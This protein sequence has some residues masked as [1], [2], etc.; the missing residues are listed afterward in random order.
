MQRVLG[1]VVAALVLAGCSSPS[2]GADSGPAEDPQANVTAPGAADIDLPEFFDC[3]RRND[4]VIIAA[5]R[6]G[7]LPGYPENAIETM[8]HN[9]D[10]GIRLFEIDVAETRD[11]VLML[12]HDDRVNRTTNGSGYVS[13]TSWEDMSGLRLVDND[14]AMTD[15]HPPKLTDALL[16]ARQTGAL[17]ELDKKKTTSFKNIITAVQAADAQNNVIL[18]S[19]NDDQAAEI[20]AI[21]PTLM[22]TA[23]A[24]GERDVAALEERGIDRDRLIAWTGTREPDSAAFARLEAAG[25]EPAFGTLGRP[26]ERLDDTYL[27][28]GDGSEYADLV[29]EGLV[30]LA[31]DVPLAVAAA[32]DADERGYA[33]CWR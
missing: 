12:M 13:D 29:T 19:Y 33:T 17:V 11:G 26:G 1:P 31:T 14:G 28:D 20:A 10:Q 2:D 25:V 18:I 23:S 24:F 16:W 5:H 21:D 9:F 4:G 7:P 15:F 27:A 8:Q 32:M 22:L 30:L 6:G 3:L